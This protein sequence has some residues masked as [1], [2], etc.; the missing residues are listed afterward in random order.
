MA[1]DISGYRF[2]RLIA[3]RQTDAR[4]AGKVMWLCLCDCGKT[5]LANTSQLKGGAR[6]SCGCAKLAGNQIK[7]KSA[8]HGHYVGNKP[9][10]TYRVWSSML[11]RCRNPN[12]QFW[13]QYGGRGIAVC[14]AWYSFASFLSDMGEKPKGLSL[15]RINNDLGYEPSNCRWATNVEQHRNRSDNLY[16][17][18][19]GETKSLAAW[20]ECFNLNE[21]TLWSRIKKEGWTIEAA[22]TTPILSPSESATRANLKRWGHV[23]AEIS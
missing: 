5:T 20:A 6:V 22:L 23:V 1:L 13:M 21:S 2:G 4:I 17:S 11:S 7:K 14:D 9:T 18:F 19:N 8:T 16:L 3:E 12:A 15:D 10:P